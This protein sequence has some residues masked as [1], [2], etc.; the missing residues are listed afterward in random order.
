MF[1]QILLSFLLTALPHGQFHR[2]TYVENLKVYTQNFENSYIAQ[3]YFLVGHLSRCANYRAMLGVL[4][5][6]YSLNYACFM[7]VW[8]YV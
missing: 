5:G 2:E 7:V 3:K 8:V 6:L 4:T 1:L